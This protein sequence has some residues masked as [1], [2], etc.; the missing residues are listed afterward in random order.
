MESPDS[1]ATTR[2]IALITGASAGIGHVFAQ[3]LAASGHDLILVARDAVRLRA[4]ADELALQHGVHAAAF[5]ADLSREDGMRGVAEHIAQSDR[6]AFLV[7][8]AGF[9]TKGKLVNRPA[10][11]QASMLQLHVMAPML[12]TR[13]ALPGMIARGSGTI[14]NVSSIA[15]FAFA[16]GVVNYGAS[17]AFLRVFSEGLALE[18]GGTG[19]HVQA[20]CP[21]FTHTEM[22]SRAAIRKETIPAFLWLDAGRVVDY[23]LAQ[24]ERGGPTVCIPDWKYKTAVVMLKHLPEW[25]KGWMRARYGRSRL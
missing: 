9:G 19:V 5:P 20:L 1:A 24:A 12:L 17:K 2:P 18:L 11:E 21:G 22:H 6:L 13:A 14:I 15:S 16:P 7:N 3:R 10:A 25:M 4:V 23:S 8:N